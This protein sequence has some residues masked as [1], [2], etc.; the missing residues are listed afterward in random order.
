MFVG[1][2]IQAGMLLSLSGAS[3]WWL[4]VRAIASTTRQA[5]SMPA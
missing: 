1:V 2:R 3:D 5:A 4:N